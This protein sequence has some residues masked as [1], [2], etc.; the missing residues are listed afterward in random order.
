MFNKCNYYDEF[1]LSKL[2]YAD[3]SM[4][5]FAIKELHFDQSPFCKGLGCF[6]KKYYNKLAEQ[7]AQTNLYATSA[8]GSFRILSFTL[9]NRLYLPFIGKV[10]KIAL[11]HLEH[12]L[13]GNVIQ[14]IL[15]SR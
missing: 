9:F 7:P 11:R 13:E 8:Q 4:Q 10:S 14:L 2:L 15:T 5:A 6:T 3:P 1:L 12:L